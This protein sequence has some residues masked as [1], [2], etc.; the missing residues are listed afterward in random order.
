M[1]MERRIRKEL[2]DQGLLDPVDPSKEDP[3][4][5]EILAEIKRCQ[6]ELKT[7]SAQNFQQLK[8][9]KKLATEEVMRQD[10]KKKLQHVDNEILEVFWR[11]H[12]TKLKKLPIMKREQELA[13]DALK[14][15]EALLK[16]IECVGDNA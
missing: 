1:S 15:R 8:R 10:L 14:E 2:E 16:Q 7:I 6:T 12:N 3:V 5:D 13:V 9:L 4:D 11:I